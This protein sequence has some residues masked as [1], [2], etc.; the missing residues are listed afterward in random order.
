MVEAER[1]PGLG[2][3]P[4][5]EAPKQPPQHPEVD[6]GHVLY[7]LALRAAAAEGLRGAPARALPA[8]LDVLPLVVFHHGARE[9]GERFGDNRRPRVRRDSPHLLSWFCEGGE[10]QSG[11]QRRACL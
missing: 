1:Q 11:V 4:V 9:G 6:A 2:V 3:V 8:V 10:G 7:A 5:D